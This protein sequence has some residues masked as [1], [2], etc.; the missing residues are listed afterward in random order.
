MEHLNEKENLEDNSDE[1]LSAG[2]INLEEAARI[3]KAEDR[4]DQQIE[5]EKVDMYFLI[6][7]VYNFLTV[8]NCIL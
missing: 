1:K 2:G 3:L 4:Y 6:L 5:R 8:Q 7:L